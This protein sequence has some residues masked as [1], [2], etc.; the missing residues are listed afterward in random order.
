MRTEDVAALT[1][2]VLRQWI[3]VHKIELINFRDALYGTHEYQNYLRSIDSDLYVG[4][5]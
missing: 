4:N 2:P 5:M 3:R 1:S